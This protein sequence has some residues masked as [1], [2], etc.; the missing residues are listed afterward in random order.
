MKRL[1]TVTAMAAA[2][3]AGGGGNPGGSGGTDT[4][5]VSVTVNPVNDAP[6]AAA[7]GVTTNEDTAVTLSVL[8]SDVEIGCCPN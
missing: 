7:D 2:L 4:A 5:T 8:A 3:A 1:V 6:S